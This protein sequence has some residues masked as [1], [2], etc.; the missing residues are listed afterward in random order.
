[1]PISRLENLT[2]QSAYG[3]EFLNYVDPRY[4]D[5]LP[6]E[7]IQTFWLFTHLLGYSL[8]LSKKDPQSTHNAP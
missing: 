7:S 2:L 4:T 6:S 8:I 1:M 5:T 3:L